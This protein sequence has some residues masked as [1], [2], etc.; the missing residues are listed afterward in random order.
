MSKKTWNCEFCGKELDEDTWEDHCYKCDK[1]PYIKCKGCG[2]E[3]KQMVM[4]FE[5]CAYCQDV[6]MA[7]MIKQSAPYCPYCS[8]TNVSVVDF[9]EN[10]ATMNC[11]DC[12]KWYKVLSLENQ[13]F[14]PYE[15]SEPPNHP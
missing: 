10:Y 8:H 4:Q 6:Q 3:I 1:Q 2:K 5:G 15:E 12:N 14:D 13:R 11:N 9:D 7:E